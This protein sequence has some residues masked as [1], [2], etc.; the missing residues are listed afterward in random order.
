[1]FYTGWFS[2]NK[3]FLEIFG[4]LD[5]MSGLITTTVICGLVG[6]T[7]LCGLAVTTVLYGLAGTT[8]LS[9]LTGSTVL[10]GMA[11]TTVL[12][13]LGTKLGQV[14]NQSVV[15]KVYFFAMYTSHC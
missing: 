11:G 13:G 15:F 3:C 6:T 8:F 1:M 9:G 2:S 10:S 5:A 4:A 14:N 7:V 12:S